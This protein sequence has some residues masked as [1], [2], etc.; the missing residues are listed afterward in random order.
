MNHYI[1]ADIQRILHKHSFLQAIAVFIGLFVI[2]IFIYFNPTFTIEMYISKMT[3]F[4]GFFPLLIGLFVFMCVY[5]DDFKCKSMQIAIGYGT[6]RK[7][8]VLAKLIES[9]LLLATTA[10]ITSILIT[11]APL[12]LDLAP[13]KQDLSYLALTVLADMLRTFGY[14]ALA[15]IPVFFSQNAINGIIAYVL[16][17]SKTIYIILMMFLEQDF[18]IGF[19]GDLRKYLLTVQLYDARTHFSQTGQFD[20]VWI[21][22]LIV[23][24]MI[25]TYLSII[26]F[27]KKE[28]EF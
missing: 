17:S 21:I 10:A 14:I 1:A 5:A 26:S 18:L 22:T 20:V 25:P 3:G 23:Y 15:T 6:P 4:L 9:V 24:V 7:N 8:I 27:N 19:T 28:L 2:Q 16:L 12:L 11:G 13:N